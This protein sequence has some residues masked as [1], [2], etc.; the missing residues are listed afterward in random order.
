MTF[1]PLLSP[2]GEDCLDVANRELCSY[3]PLEGAGSENYFHKMN[4]Q[5]VL[6][7]QLETLNLKL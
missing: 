4:T 1:S 7:G 6:T 3:F 2:Q 5:E